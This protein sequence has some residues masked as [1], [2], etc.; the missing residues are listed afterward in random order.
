VS[1]PSKRRDKSKDLALIGTTIAAKYKVLQLLGQ[2]GFGSVFLVEIIAGMVGEKL[3]LKLIPSEF[4]QDPKAKAQ[5]L[6]EIRVAMR[7]VNKYIVQVRDVGETE[8]GQ[9][10]YT[11]DY[12]P[13]ETLSVVLQRE[14]RLSPP[15]AVPIALRILEALKTAHTA[16]VIHRDLKPA[17]V[18]VFQL[19]GHETCRVLDF[20]IA[21]A[22]S[23]GQPGGGSFLGSPHYMPPEQ[24]L[25]EQLGF[26]TDTY[27]VGVILY[28]CL[29]GQKPFH[30]RTPQEVYNDLKKRPAVP[31]DQFNPDLN[32][33]PGLSKVICRALE[34]NPE[35][36]YQTAKEFFAEL[37]GALEGKPE[38]APAQPAGPLQQAARPAAPRR[39]VAPVSGSRPIAA[40]Q[41]S[42]SGAIVGVA[43]GLGVLAIALLVIMKGM[44]SS[45]GNPTA[46]P[47]DN[48]RQ[49]KKVADAPPTPAPPEI[50]PGDTN[51]DP[52][53]QKDVVE[54]D[55]R[56][57]E[58]EDAERAKVLIVQATDESKK[59]KD[60]N[61][62]KV[63]ELCNDA[64]VL[65]YEGLDAMRL[66][67]F[68]ELKLGL[69]DEA[70]KSLADARA[71]AGDNVDVRLLLN[72]L[73]AQSGSKEPD[74]ES[75]AKTLS[76]A[77]EAW[78][79]EPADRDTTMAI[80]G[81]L[82][83]HGDE[84][85]ILVALKKAEEMKIDDPLVAKIREKWHVEIPARR[86]ARALETLQAAKAA[87][88][89][90]DLE[91]A[92]AKAKEGFG[93]KPIPDL[94]FILAEAYG[95]LGKRKEMMETLGE[96]SAAVG[97]DAEGLVRVG[98]LYGRAHLD[99]Y[100]AG[101]RKDKGSIEKAL[102]SLDAAVEILAKNKLPP[103]LAAARTYRARCNA[104]LGNVEKVDEDVT[105]A[106]KLGSFREDPFLVYIQG[107]SYF[108]LV[109]RVNEPDRTKS[110]DRAINRLVSFRD[111]HGGKND[112][113]CHHLLGKC[114]L[115][116]QAYTK[117]VNC[118]VD[119]EKAA[120]KVPVAPIPELYEDWGQTLKMNGEPM[121][122]GQ[123]FEK[124]FDLHLAKGD[125]RAEDLC[126]KAA[127]CYLQDSMNKR[128][129]E[130]L[131]RGLQKF[132]NST[133]LKN[134]LQST[135]R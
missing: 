1:T 106:N 84:A 24:F 105:V 95:G 58:R 33:F 116:K 57:K 132:P 42:S 44:S 75:I 109:N 25:N 7:M 8:T 23:T 73:D 29:T 97:D 78:K 46:P 64:L 76:D 74:P 115:E 13:G 39:R 22:V 51:P 94:G 63:R 129:A 98:I 50:M 72:L 128:A 77:A 38:P 68:A 82:D 107:E 16:G 66:R 104:F 17:N 60:A 52:T 35:L 11:M 5:F 36:R 65:G 130:I 56:D 100:E 119:A 49:T 70:Q 124:A 110:L 41:K 67:G 15:R 55:P 112:P 99:E 103:L 93:I 86:E 53:S 133:R 80:I 123:K 62:E 32:T 43:A 85:N 4:C 2:G 113:R 111:D 48:S 126:E 47:P 96:L 34:R 3:A 37:K 45:N 125:P 131:E 117:A 61:W 108:I 59:E 134:L 6:N 18:M 102:Q 121:K 28:E 89:A 14:G 10:Y 92:A 79:R 54:K 21:T 127:A 27:S 9:L 30:G 31:P 26:Y 83:G 118:F 19:D 88:D 91:G 40:P 101:G 122:A 20:G 12:C 90:K 120:R 135:R 69:F 87:F 81:H 114:H 71:R